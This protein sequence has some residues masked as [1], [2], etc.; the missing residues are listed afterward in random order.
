MLVAK[1]KAQ[2]KECDVVE[3]L[4]ELGVDEVGGKESEVLVLLGD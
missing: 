2:K 1:R 3:Q 4:R